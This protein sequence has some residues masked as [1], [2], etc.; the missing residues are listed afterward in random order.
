MEAK[1]TRAQ[2]AQLATQSKADAQYAAG[3]AAMVATV[4]EF[5]IAAGAYDGNETFSPYDAPFP[6]RTLS[7]TKGAVIWHMVQAGL[8]SEVKTRGRFGETITNYRVTER[9]TQA[10]VKLCR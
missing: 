5:G 10:A 4:L 7:R 2:A 8:L 3:G 9:G 1:K 6:K